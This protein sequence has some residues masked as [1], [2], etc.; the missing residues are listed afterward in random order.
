M[1]VL[2]RSAAETPRMAKWER[3]G[4][5]PAKNGKKKYKK[6]ELLSG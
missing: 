4:E 6:D 5:S 1:M 3:R 2:N